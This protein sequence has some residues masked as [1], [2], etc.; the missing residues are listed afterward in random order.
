[1]GLNLNYNRSPQFEIAA[2]FLENSKLP[3]K[4][5]AQ[6]V[7]VAE[8]TVYRWAAGAGG[9]LYLEERKRK[10]ALDELQALPDEVK[11]HIRDN[12]ITHNPGDDDKVVIVDDTELSSKSTPLALPTPE[13]NQQPQNLPAKNEA[14]VSL[15][16]RRGTCFSF[17]NSGMRQY[18]A[19]IEDYYRREGKVPKTIEFQKALGHRRG[20]IICSAREAFIRDNPQL[21]LLNKINLKKQRMSSILSVEPTLNLSSIIDKLPPNA[22]ELYKYIEDFFSKNLLIP[23]FI[24]VK[25]AGYKS[26]FR[27]YEQA[28][29]AFVIT[30]IKEKNSGQPTQTTLPCPQDHKVQPLPQPVLTPE[31]TEYRA[32]PAKELSIK[33][34]GVEIKVPYPG[35]DKVSAVLGNILQTIVKSGVQL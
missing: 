33:L 27:P 26:K 15:E 24:E 23:S 8:K 20:M 12:L 18:Y 32:E 2:Q 19:F 28:R 1:M 35:E 11:E 10:L 22:M 14:E 21:G 25:L 17:L 9:P 7:G 30:H 5:I 3:I 6:I 13:L 4:D 16:L 31:K 34:N 29:H